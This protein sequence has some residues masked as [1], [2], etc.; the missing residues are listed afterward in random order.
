MPAEQLSEG[1]TKTRKGKAGGG[2]EGEDEGDGEEEEE[3]EALSSFV[4]NAVMVGV[5][6]APHLLIIGVFNDRSFGL[7]FPSSTFP[8]HPEP[9]SG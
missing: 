8:L 4:G 1:G 2:E 6:W 7:V 9:L 3:E 5:D